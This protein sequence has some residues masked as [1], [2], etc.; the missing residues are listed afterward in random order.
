MRH[1]SRVGA[2]LGA[3]VAAAWVSAVV[4]AQAPATA[5]PQRVTSLKTVP[6]PKPPDLSR[7]VR[8]EQALVVLGKALFWDVQLSSDNSVACA[9]CHFH[10]GADHRLQ[11]QLTTARDEVGR[12]LTLTPGDFPFHA[13]FMS[14]GHRAGSAGMFP[15]EFTGTSAEGG[16][17][18]GAPKDDERLPRVGDIRVRQVTARNAPS[19]INAV[20]MYRSFWDG[21]ASDIFNGASPFGESDPGAHLLVDRPEGLVR[22]VVRLERSSLASQAVG[23][24]LDGAEMS[25]RGRTWA[26]IGRKLLDA[27]P[28]ADQFIARDDSVLAPWVNQAG[29]GVRPDV[30][31]RSLVH[32]AFQPDLFRADVLV[33][34]AGDA[35]SVRTRDRTDALFRQDEFNFGFFLGLAVQAYEATLVSDDS[36]YDRFLDGDTTALTRDALIG[37]EMFNRRACA[38][39]HVDPELTLATHSGVKGAFGFQ[40]L[41]LDAGY[42]HTGVEPVANDP[43]A[44]AQDPFGRWFSRTVQATPSHATGWR[45]TFKTPSLRNVEFTGPYFHTGSK[46]TLEQIVDFYTIGGDY[47]SVALRRWGPDASEKLYMPAVMRSFTDDR[48]KFERAPF[49]HPALCVPVGHVGDEKAVARQAG[50]DRL[51]QDRWALVPAVGAKG[52][53]VPLQTFDELLRGV[54]IDGSRAHTMAE[55]CGEP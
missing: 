52:N 35:Q 36:P 29:P 13:N 7:Y 37:L 16:A 5:G 6:V 32:A 34:A 18:A 12:N 54:G 10:A 4:G 33:D 27:R 40:G 43:G 26:W 8:D 50:S 47:G 11:N 53:A 25:Y 31:Y 48:V 21:R 3:V 30:T 45:G 51:A 23:P 15:H 14:A 41:G 42:F 24:P 9:T 17:D 39:C 49:D 19:V 44:S 22:Q 2:V 38:S 1:R 20:F 46:S 55:S 28:L